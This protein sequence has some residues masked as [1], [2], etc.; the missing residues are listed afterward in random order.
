MTYTFKLARRLARF[1][2]GML[3]GIVFTSACAGTDSAVGPE[4]GSNPLNPTSL[5]VFPD[6][7]T[8]DVSGEM[9]FAAQTVTDSEGMAAA[10]SQ[11]GRWR[12]IVRVD[13]NPDSVAVAAG[14]ARN[15][16]VSGQTAYGSVVTP[17]VRW[18]ATGGT[19]D[20]AGKYIAGTVPGRFRVIAAATNDV[21]D[22]AT[23][24]ITSPGQ[25][26]ERVELSPASV[27]LPLGG[28]K[29]FVTVGKA[30]DGAIVAVSPQYTATGGIIS[31][32]GVYQAGRTAGT[33]RV[34]ATD[35]TSNLADTSA[36]IVEALTATLQAVVLSPATASLAVGGTQRFT[37]TGR[38]SDGSTRSVTVTWSASGGTIS[39]EGDY[40]AGSA[41][42]TYR[43]VG[44]QTGG[45]LADTATVT[46]TAPSPTLQ[47]LVLTPPS[48]TLQSGATQRFA[49]SGLMSDGSTTTV[50]AT[51]SATGG[52]ITSAGVYTAGASAGS[53]R[54]IA[55]Q[56]DGTKADTSSVTV[57]VNTPPPPSGS[58]GR[59]VNV[60]TLSAFSSALAGALPG[61]CILLAPGTY[62]A[63]TSLRITKS[64]TASAPITIQGGGSSNTVIDLRQQ[65]MTFEKASYVKLRKMR[66][67]G[68]PQRGLWLRDSHYN[69]LDS[70]EVDNTRNEAIA[71][72][73]LSK[74]NVI[75]N[76]WI[77]NTGVVNPQWGEGVYV[78]G[79]AEAGYPQDAGVTDN[80]VIGNKIGP[81]VRAQAVDVSPGADRTL[82]QG[83]TIDGT[84]AVCCGVGY[85][86]LIDVIASGVI[87]ENNTISKGT[88]NA[89]R[90]LAPA[91][92]T[93]TGSIAR[94][95]TIDLQNV[96]DFSGSSFGFNLTV[97]TNQPGR[98]SIKCSNRV[99]NGSFSNVTC[100]P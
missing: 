96:H 93:M 92:Y 79:S 27:S 99:I 48:V 45:T 98:V 17:F 8:I 87:V 1:R 31:S 26:I 7:A 52:T 85:G 72:K 76:S 38:M 34:I 35:T 30:N 90:F 82:I 24:V 95:N 29:Q 40:A 21:A 55:T 11:R 54:V 4:S 15:F 62:S 32:E 57:T 13:L 81:Y 44:T 71:I 22:T 77:H 70:L 83:N 33:F 94:N 59:T 58:C 65:E 53:F 78:G 41:A 5:D 63:T 47:A 67:T 42:E 10:S 18:T 28:S 88:P 19:V 51:Y 25:T 36:V 69:T 91:G 37:A 43:V 75:K 97:N 68:F 20:T 49:V 9:Q 86:S 14:T 89:V 66:I 39:S 56:Q 12:R 16:A 60:N 80:Q 3:L 46:I 23:V 6:S 61:D 2:T 50:N 84:G 100:S 73:N 74:F 64:G